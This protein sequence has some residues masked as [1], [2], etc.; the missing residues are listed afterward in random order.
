MTPEESQPGQTS[1]NKPERPAQGVLEPEAVDESPVRLKG[2]AG[3]LDHLQRLFGR[4]VEDPWRGVD[5]L[6]GK[7]IGFIKRVGVHIA[8]LV[9]ALFIADGNNYL[10]QTALFYFGAICLLPR[11]FSLRCNSYLFPAIT[12]LGLLVISLL[13]GYSLPVA[14]FLAGA[15]GWAQRL[16]TKRFRLGLDW[17]PAPFLLGLLIQTVRYYDA[18]LGLFILTFICGVGAY[19]IANLLDQRKQARLEED[20]RRRVDAAAP[21][22]HLYA[23]A[24]ELQHKALALPEDL[25]VSVEAIALSG[26]NIL[27]SMQQNPAEA[28]SGA[29]FLN[30]Y[31]PAAHKIVDDYSRLRREGRGH[32]EIEAVLGQV[33]EIIDR[34]GQAFQQEHISLLRNDAMQLNVEL[35]LLDKLLKMDGK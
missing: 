12:S 5:L 15:Q 31:L 21:F 22:A 27:L 28:Q 29:R 3:P 32:Q 35:K 6:K 17:L 14:V 10:M 20:E 9:A 13:L 11:G 16:L 2:G 33:D 34:L 30:R 26:Q 25:Q 1:R 8:A 18:P 24:D 23:S 19:Y 7:I 4:H